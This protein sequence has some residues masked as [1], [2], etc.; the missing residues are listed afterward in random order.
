MNG[1]YLPEIKSYA[2][3]NFVPEP[4]KYDKKKKDEEFGSYKPEKW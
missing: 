1:D 4:A 2:N 3:K